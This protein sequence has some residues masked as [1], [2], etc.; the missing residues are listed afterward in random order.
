MNI[1][2]ENNILFSIMNP[3]SLSSY[4]FF[5]INA[6]FLAPEFIKQ[7]LEE[8]EEECINKSGLSKQEFEIRK[9]EIESSIKFFRS[10]EYEESLKRS[11]KLI[12]DLDDID[13]LA[14]AI[15]KKSI[16]WSN[17]I[18]LKEQN[19]IKTLTTSEVLNLFLKGII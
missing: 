7:E 2:L 12:S 1:V 4:L 11:A 9:A 13:F 5:S 14:L 10:F 8:H 16:I 17:D 6:N 19:L 3:K 15:S 18:H